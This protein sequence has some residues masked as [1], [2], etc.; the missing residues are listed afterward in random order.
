MNKYFT[1]LLAFLAATCCEAKPRVLIRQTCG[2]KDLTFF[3]KDGPG[4]LGTL[5]PDS[6]ILFEVP[7]DQP[8]K[9]HLIAGEDTRRIAGIWLMPGNATRSAVWDHCSNRLL[10][11]D[12]LPIDLDDL[13]M[14]NLDRVNQEH[15]MGRDSFLKAMVSIE[16]NY[17]QQHPDSFLAVYYLASFIKDPDIETAKAY[18]D[19]VRPANAK[20]RQMKEIDTYLNNYRYKYV[21]SI[22]DPFYEFTAKALSG[23]DFD[24]RSLNDK[25]IVLY[26]CFS[27]CGPCGRAAG[28]LAEVY[29][30]YKQQ[31]LELISFSCDNTDEDWRGSVQ[32]HHYPGINVSDLTG[33]NSPVFLHYSVNAFPF[34]VVFDKSKHISIMTSGAEEV[35]LLEEKVRELLARK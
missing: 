7:A 1:A 23:P 22:G 28:P 4:S 8:V 11:D 20:Y 30:K 10:P 15:P 29:E 5:L 19:K 35:P 16:E 12:T 25:V 6:S 21:P 32:K 14:T 9:L 31:G 26:F 17:V 24:S 27:G 34:F 3:Y 18:A 33:F 2:F 13:P